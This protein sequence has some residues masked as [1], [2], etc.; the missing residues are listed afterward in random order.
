VSNE[1]LDLLAR[2][3]TK[4]WRAAEVDGIS[5]HKRRIKLMLTD[6]ETQSIAETKMI[7]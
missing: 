6:Q 2:G 4:F 7:I 5:L 3:V 1:G